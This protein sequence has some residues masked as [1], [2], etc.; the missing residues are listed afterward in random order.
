MDKL[1][2]SIFYEADNFCKEFNKYLQNNSPKTNSVYSLLTIV[3]FLIK[4]QNQ[5]QYYIY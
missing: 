1:L 4:N 3:H 5:Y 2:I